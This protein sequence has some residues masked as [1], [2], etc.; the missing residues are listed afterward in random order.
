M[1]YRELGTFDTNIFK[2]LIDSS[3]GW[4]TYPN[5]SPAH[6]MYT[7]TIKDQYD[8]KRILARYYN[9]DAFKWIKIHRLRP[10][11]EITLHSDPTNSR[12]NTH[13]VHLVVSTNNKVI[14]NLDGEDREFKTGHIYEIDNTKPHY[15]QNNG[16]TDRIHLMAIVYGHLKTEE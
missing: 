12:E 4:G 5:G 11:Q 14:F 13:V 7:K 10:D 8:V 1:V 16:D 15:V 2:S 6:G 3:E 9:I